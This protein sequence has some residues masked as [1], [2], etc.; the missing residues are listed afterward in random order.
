[1]PG[2]RLPHHV[3]RGQGQVTGDGE[4]GATTLDPG[5]R[6]SL[7]GLR[8]HV[9]L[10]VNVHPAEALAMT[11]LVAACTSRP[12]PISTRSGASPAS[13]ARAASNFFFSCWAL[14]DR[15]PGRQP[16]GPR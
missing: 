8:A 11:T 1:M 6:Y 15:C 7:S 5:D 13:F 3:K 16:D 14:P 9:S 12:K 10:T 2:A 4:G